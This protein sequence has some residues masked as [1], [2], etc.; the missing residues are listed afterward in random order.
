MLYSTVSA[1]HTVIPHI[2]TQCSMFRSVEAGDSI[3]IVKSNEEL[4]Y[5][6]SLRLGCSKDISAVGNVFPCEFVEKWV[7]D[8]VM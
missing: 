1:A 5:P 2:H 4:Y 8:V 7:K 3:S 6:H